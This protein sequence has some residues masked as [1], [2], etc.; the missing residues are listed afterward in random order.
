MPPLLHSYTSPGTPQIIAPQ[1]LRLGFCPVRQYD[2]SSMSQIRASIRLA[3][4]ITPSHVFYALST[5]TNAMTT[6]ALMVLGAPVSS[7][8]PQTALAFAHAAV[9]SGHRV[10]RVFFF[11][12]GVHCGSDLA[13]AGAEQSPIATQWSEFAAQEN[14]DLVVCVASALKRGIV[15]ADESRRYNKASGNLTPGFNLSGLGQWIDACLNADRVITFG[16]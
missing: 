8:S 16:S 14:I 13:I 3:I 6:F 2:D 12:D 10:L 4:C 5:Q 15:D 11:H 1:P 7:Q 9:Q